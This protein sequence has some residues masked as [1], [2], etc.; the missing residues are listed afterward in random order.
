MKGEGNEEKEVEDSKASKTMILYKLPKSS[1][2][3]LQLLQNTKSLRFLFNFFTPIVIRSRLSPP[4]IAAKTLNMLSKPR[5]VFSSE[6]SNLKTKSAFDDFHRMSP[7][8]PFALKTPQNNS[9]V[10]YLQT[11]QTMPFSHRKSD[12]SSSNS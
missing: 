12:A 11:R 6:P 8:S 7:P 3:F 9:N 1:K 4:V 2:D 5:F 10:V